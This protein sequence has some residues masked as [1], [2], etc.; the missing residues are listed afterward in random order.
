MDVIIWLDD[1]VKIS[2]DDNI[3]VIIWLDDNVIIWMITFI[4]IENVTHSYATL[5]SLYDGSL[6]HANCS[7][8]WITMPGQ[9]SVCEMDHCASPNAV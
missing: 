3:D 2:L 7:V 1:M 8:K 6:N 4:I 9:L 5:T